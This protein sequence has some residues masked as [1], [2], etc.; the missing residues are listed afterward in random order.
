VFFRNPGKALPENPMPQFARPEFSVFQS[1]VSSGIAV[2]TCLL[3]APLVG[4]GVFRFGKGRDVSLRQ[5]YSKRHTEKLKTPDAQ[6][7]ALG[8]P[9]GTFPRFPEEPNTAIGN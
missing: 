1:G 2:T 7:V 8:S 5:C 3:R 9:G 6:T 4:G